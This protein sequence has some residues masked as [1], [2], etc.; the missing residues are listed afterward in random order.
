M[1]PNQ[2]RESIW[3]FLVA[4]ELSPEP[5]TGGGKGC[6]AEP[7]FEPSILYFTF[8]WRGSTPN[9]QDGV[10]QSH[11]RDGHSQNIPQPPILPFRSPNSNLSLLWLRNPSA[12]QLFH[13]HITAQDIPQ[14]WVSTKL[15][16]KLHLINCE[17]IHIFSLI[18]SSE[19][20]FPPH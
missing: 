9:H 7:D 18:Y 10:S 20:G 6:S 15:A 2:L 4:A 12:F 3:V 8:I 1:A 5:D 16:D 11:T 14:S 19:P 17:L 13:S